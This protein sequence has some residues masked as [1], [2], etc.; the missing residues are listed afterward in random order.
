M[1]DTCRA[2][3]GRD[4]LAQTLLEY[5]KRRYEERSNPYFAIAAYELSRYIGIELPAWIEGYVFGAFDELAKLYTYD[6]LAVE[7]RVDST[8]QSIK[9]V[10]GRNK[11]DPTAQRIKQALGLSMRGSGTRVSSAYK[12]LRDIRLAE[13]VQIQLW[14]QTKLDIA[15]DVVAGDFGLHRST[16]FRAYTKFKDTVNPII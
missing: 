15:Y 12:Q 11:V 16:V 3:K 7:N 9:R 14:N 6:R 2:G 10:P 4:G 1:P 13:A 8:A 5:Y